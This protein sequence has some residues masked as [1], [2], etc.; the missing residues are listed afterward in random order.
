MVTPLKLEG[1]AGPSYAGPPV[2][3]G[4][5]TNSPNEP[6]VLAGIAMGASVVVVSGAVVILVGAT[7]VVVVVAAVV[8]G[9]VVDAGSSS[10]VQ[11]VASRT[12]ATR[13]IDQRFT[14]TS[15]IV[16]ITLRHILGDY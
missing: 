16:A 3:N 12:V 15:K 5:E 9:A 13:R 8:D 4:I 1:V 14:T 7:A 10:D 2:R 11:A 6:R